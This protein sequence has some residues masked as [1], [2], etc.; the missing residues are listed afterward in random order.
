MSPLA[1]VWT[2]VLKDLSLEK[3]S[4]EMLSSMLIF[5]LL[6][7]LV[8][9]FSFDLRVD[10]VSGVAPGVLW[11]AISFAGM[12]GLARSF[13]LE[14]DQGCL[15]GLLLC[16]VDRSLLYLG[17]MISN[18][19]F[20]SLTELAVVPM[21]FALFN[22][23]FHLLL[24][25]ILLLGTIG[26]SAVGTIVS[27]MTVHARAREV[28]LPILLFPLVLPAL[29]AAVKLTGGVLDGQPWGEIRNWMELLVGFDVIFMV[30]SYLAFEHVIEE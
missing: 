29:I 3:R 18:L 24:L 7:V 9:S 10:E 21:C 26:F 20:I 12:L 2:L 11:V 17:K 6:V 28:M 19:A 14:R 8:F 1:Q 22:L 30:M 16:P 15:D 5:A 27:A 25:P 23:T 4:R 13:V